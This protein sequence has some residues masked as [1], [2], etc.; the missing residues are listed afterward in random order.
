MKE[1]RAPPS[2]RAARPRGRARRHAT[3]NP[4]SSSSTGTSAGRTRTSSNSARRRSRAASPAPRGAGSTG[5]GRRSCTMV[6]C[7]GRAERSAK[8]SIRGP[9]AR[10]RLHASRNGRG[11]ELPLARKGMG[12]MGPSPG[13]TRRFRRTRPRGTAQASFAR[14]A[15]RGPRGPRTSP[16]ASISCARP[17]FAGAA[18]ASRAR[19]PS[20]G[21]PGVKRHASLVMAVTGPISPASPLDVN[22]HKCA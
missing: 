8:S 10:G 22:G 19:P 7:R 2:R 21:A 6:T 16:S 15:S 9:L 17:R 13:P 12:K 4:S 5:E 14:R 1:R 20:Q 18:A 11:A 3:P